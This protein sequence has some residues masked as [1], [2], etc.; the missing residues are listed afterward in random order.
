[1][2]LTLSVCVCVHLFVT[3]TASS[4]L[5]L[6]GIEPFLGH[7]FSM[8]RT[9]KRC[10]SIFDLCPLTPKIYSPKFAQILPITRFVRQIDRRCLGLQWRFSRMA[11]SMEPC[12]MLWGRPLF[13]GNEICA[14]RGDP[15]AYRLVFTT[16][17]CFV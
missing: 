2:S 12:K 15:V 14:R 1:M 10:S 7:R 4:F 11:N 9:T 3:N 16:I 5:F 8:T 6:D 13:H 17:G